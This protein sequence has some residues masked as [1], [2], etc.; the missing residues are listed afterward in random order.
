LG[1][2][3]DT[4]VLINLIDGDAD[5]RAARS[6]FGDAGYLSVI[7]TVELHAGALVD[8]RVDSE[9]SRRIAEIVDSLIELPFTS[10]EAEAYAR[11]IGAVG[12]ARRLIIDRMIAATAV[13]NGLTLVTANP[14]D[15]RGIPGLT[16]EDWSN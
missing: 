6:R 8:G 7:S 15:F 10:N 5:L 2:L 11:M 16:I 9:I 4:N 1:Y 13:T 3:L 14:R 12:F